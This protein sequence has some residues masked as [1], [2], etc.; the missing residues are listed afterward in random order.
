MNYEEKLEK[1]EWGRLHYS[2]SLDRGLDNIIYILPWVL[3]KCPD[4]KLHVFYGLNTW[5]AA[6][7]SRNNP[8]E[9]KK[10][11]IMLAEIEK[12]KDVITFH[13]RIGQ[14]E[15]ADEWKK[16]WC[17]FQPTAFSETYC[18]TAKEAQASFTPIIC[19]NEAA[20]QT[21]VGQFGIRIGGYAYSKESR[22]NYVKELIK[23][24][25]NKDHWEW[26]AKRAHLGIAGF[27]WEEVYQNYW[28]KLLP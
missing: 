2:S 15:L 27:S 22:E 26:W 19:S 12:L 18:I 23:M 20:L 4:I 16:A 9:L 10:I 25:E 13:G 17:W 14:K 7:K 1:V 3:D 24:Y 8:D 11:D 6:A 28:R 5:I 21:T